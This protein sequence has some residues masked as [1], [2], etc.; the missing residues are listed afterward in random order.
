ME[1]MAMKRDNS[2]TEYLGTGPEY[3]IWQTVFWM[4]SRLRI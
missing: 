1:Q 3:A 4:Q 2:L